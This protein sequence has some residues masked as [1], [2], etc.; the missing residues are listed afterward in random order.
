[1]PK[2]ALRPC[3]H[4]APDGTRCRL[5]R[6]CPRHPEDPR[7][8][9]SPSGLYNTSRW[10]AFRSEYL[11]T[12]PACVS[13]RNRATVVDHIQPHR[14]DPVRFWA[15]PFQPMCSSCHGRKT[16]RRDGGFGRPRKPNVARPKET[17]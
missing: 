13:C 2:R 3:T 9:H 15:G 10:V 8:Q 17:R 14:G 7:V 6:P 5:F 16:L 11:R 12:H 1:M 4:V